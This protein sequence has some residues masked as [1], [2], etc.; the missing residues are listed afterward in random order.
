M[1]NDVRLDSMDQVLDDFYHGKPV[2][3]VDAVDRENEG[4]LAVATEKITPELVNFMLREARGLICVTISRGVAQRLQLP[5][6]VLNNNSRFQTPFAVSIDSV[7]FAE[8]GIT[9]EA[10]ANTMRKLTDNES[11]AEDFVSPGNVFPLI[12]NPAGVIGRQGQ[13][14]GSYDLA[15]IV[16]LEPSAVIC[17]ILNPDGTMAKGSQ[18]TRFAEKHDLKI[19]SVQEIIQHRI[20]R[21]VLLRESSE[22]QLDTAYGKFEVYIFHDDVE[23]KEHIALVYGDLTTATE[24][25]LTRVHSECLTGDVFGSRRCDCGSQL[26]L[27]MKSIVA[28]GLGIVIYMRQEGRGIGLTNKLKAYALQ[29]LGHDTVEANIELGFEPDLR[30]YAATAKILKQLQVTNVRLMTNNP[31]KIEMLEKYGVTVS[32]RVPLIVPDDEF[33]REYLKTKASKLGHLL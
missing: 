28:Q 3:I 21:E 1:R 11:K 26:D 15:R 33:S 8:N 13:T 29:D 24:G 4:D 25:V 16:G 7:E 5:F 14:E 17:E 30:N 31:M 2:I 23:N 22:S 19:T 20:N 10:R 6:Q 18:I 9:A 12:A 32:E 27:A